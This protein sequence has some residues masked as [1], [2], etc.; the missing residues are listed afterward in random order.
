MHLFVNK[1]HVDL[2]Y[3]KKVRQLRCYCLDLFRKKYANFDVIAL[4]KGNDIEVGTN[5]L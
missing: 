4:T 1:Y 3:S 2:I 5:N